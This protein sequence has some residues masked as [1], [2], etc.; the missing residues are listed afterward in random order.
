MHTLLIS[1]FWIHVS[2]LSSASLVVIVPSVIVVMVCHLH[3]S[4]GVGV[5]VAVRVVDVHLHHVLRLAPPL[6]EEKDSDATCSEEDSKQ[7]STCFSKR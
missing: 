4:I 7:N 3:H 6:A 5:V 2:C 1:I